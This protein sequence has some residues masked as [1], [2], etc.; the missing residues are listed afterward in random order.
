MMEEDPSWKRCMQPTPEAMMES[1]PD[2]IPKSTPM[3]MLEQH[4]YSRARGD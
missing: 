4:S 3:M 1:E 2:M